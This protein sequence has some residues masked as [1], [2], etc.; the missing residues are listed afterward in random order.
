MVSLYQAQKLV[1]W[2]IARLGLIFDQ[3]GRFVAYG[4]ND[5][6]VEDN[7]PFAS[8]SSTD[9]STDFELGPILYILN[10]FLDPVEHEQVEENREIDFNELQ[11][12]AQNRN[13]NFDE[14]EPIEP[15]RAEENIEYYEHN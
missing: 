14:N 4:D 11:L 3:D 7:R 12:E 6:G 1:K 5:A 10:R 2:A 8:D 15:N 13:F 9:S